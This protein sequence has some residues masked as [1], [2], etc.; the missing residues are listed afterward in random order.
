MVPGVRANYAA[1]IPT[2]VGCLGLQMAGD[3]VQGVD[4]TPTAMV[5]PPCSE[6]AQ[7]ATDLLR[8]YFDDARTLLEVPLE[9]VGTPYQKRVWEEL[10]RIPPGEVR[11]Y[12]DVARAAG[13]SARA[14]G[15]ACGANPV[16]LFVPCHRVVGADGPGGFSMGGARAQWIKCWLL[17]HEGVAL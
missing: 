4:L 10:L 1:V 2:P 7:R 14:V 9:L 8:R 3:L 11:T 12:G 15:G 16:P 17:Q 6:A 13:G 5:L